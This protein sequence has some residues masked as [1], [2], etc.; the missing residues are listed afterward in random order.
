MLAAVPRVGPVVGDR[1]MPDNLGVAPSN[2]QFF[3]VFVLD[4]ANPCVI[5]PAP[6]GTG[7]DDCAGAIALRPG[8][9]VQRP[10]RIAGVRRY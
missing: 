7:S 10:V 5:V 1:P 9:Y 3:P 4:K 6:H 8:G 2:W